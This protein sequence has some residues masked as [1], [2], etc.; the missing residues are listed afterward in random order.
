MGP[1]PR[2]K[3]LI[4]G[5]IKGNQWSIALIIRPAISWG[6]LRGDP[7]GSREF[8]KVLKVQGVLFPRADRYKW[9]EKKIL[10]NGLINIWGTGVVGPCL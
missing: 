6:V 7:I 5:L 8:D 10:V 1:P 9:G 3:T 4:A 2:N